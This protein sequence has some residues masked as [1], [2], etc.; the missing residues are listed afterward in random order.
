MAHSKFAF[1]VLSMLLLAVVTSPLSAAVIY[2]D[3]TEGIEDEA[4]SLALISLPVSDDFDPG[5]N[6]SV[7]NSLIGTHIQSNA[8]TGTTEFYNGNAMRFA[9]DGTRSATTNPI[10]LSSAPDAM[11]SF[12]FKIGGPLDTA[13]FE[14]ADAGEDVMLDYST[15]AG[16]TWLSLVTIDTE[17]LQFRD[18]WGLFSS[19]V[20]AMSPAAISSATMFRFYQPNHSNAEFDNWAIDDFMIEGSGIPGGGGCTVPEPSTYLMGALALLGLSLYGWRRTRA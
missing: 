11:I 13:L 2:E 4:G 10:D 14:N 7:W 19:G 6:A 9:A 17:D 1:G 16:S 5:L 18:T 15:N 12:R 3:E 20:A 8:S